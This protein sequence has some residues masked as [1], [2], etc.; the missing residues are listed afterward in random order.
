MVKI[1]FCCFSHELAGSKSNAN[2]VWSFSKGKK[3]IKGHEGFL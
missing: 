1:G 2:E 3:H